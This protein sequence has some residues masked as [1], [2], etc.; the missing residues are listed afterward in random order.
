M[1]NI[2][3]AMGDEAGING[4]SSSFTMD[5]RVPIAV[6]ILLVSNLVM[7]IWMSAAFY[8]KQNE[9]TDRFG[10][11]F[12]SIENTILLMQEQ[13]FTRQEATI[14][15]ENIR[16]T[17]RRQDSDIKELNTLFRNLLLSQSKN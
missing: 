17:N 6:V 4:R 1:E 3:H 14:V 2:D 13:I 15:L 10:D 7:A 8:T 11:N 16:Q 12:A 9:Q 5:R